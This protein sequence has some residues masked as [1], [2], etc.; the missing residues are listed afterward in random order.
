MPT[1]VGAMT[2][3]QQANV[4]A[5]FAASPVDFVSFQVIASSGV[6]GNTQLFLDD[7]IYSTNS[8]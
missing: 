7:L 8:Q 2:P 6:L 1:N 4:N 5:V 3:M